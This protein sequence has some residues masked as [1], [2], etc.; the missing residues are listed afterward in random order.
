MEKRKT[1]LDLLRVVTM[2]GIVIFHHFPKKTLNHIVELS[3]GFTKDLYFYD[4]VNNMHLTGGH[5][6]K[7]SLLMDFCY[8]HF[9][10][11]GNFIF[12]L[13]TGYFLFGREISFPKRVRTV[14]R[15]LY[16]ILF[17]GI[18]FTLINF[19]LLVKFWPFSSYKTYLPIFTLPNWLS[20]SNM[21][22][23][24][25]YGCFILIVLPLLK[26]FENRLTQKT[27]LCLALTLSF[28]HLLSY[29]SFFPDLWLSSRMLDFILFYYL[30][31]YISKYK[32]GVK[33]RTLL[34]LFFSYLLMYFTY[35][36]YWRYSCSILYE[37]SKYSYIKV[38]A[39]YICSLIYAVLCFL[40]FNCIKMPKLCSNIISAIS[41]KTIGIYI[42][43]FNVLD[44][45]FIMADYL[46]WH[47]WTR[48]GYF[49]FVII[50]SLVLFVIGFFVDVV[51][52]WSYK[53][54]EQ[55][56]I[57]SYS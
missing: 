16:A 7:V 13:I 50:N 2:Y 23:L 54:I 41:D 19:F 17:Y 20:G 25:A 57:N 40:I 38:M 55:K 29:H 52:K 56:V 46:G 45:S 3:G 37:P 24:Q 4:F 28:L 6:S 53:L 30:G 33:L 31:G 49:L 26:M 27:H 9:G 14:A 43:H 10:K 47:D 34:I 39:P 35:E 32:P 15:V 44:I 1:N 8:G 42:F 51:R 12:M 22:Y 36:S 18:I 5:V 48:K 21:W 11:G